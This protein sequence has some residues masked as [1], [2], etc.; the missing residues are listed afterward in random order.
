MK[1]IIIAGLIIIAAA[2]NANAQD[3]SITSDSEK[4][5]LENN[6]VKV[7]QYVSIPK[8]NVCGKGVHSH[9]AHLT[10]IL[11]DAEVE[12]TLPDGKKVQQ[13][14]PAGT[15]F[16]SE[17]ETHEVKNIGASPIKIEIIETKN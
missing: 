17:A 13:K 9:A 7:T 3:K 15:T 14:A 5:V 6:K 8:G 10:V 4:I 16:W 11:T 1:K 2:T 12:V